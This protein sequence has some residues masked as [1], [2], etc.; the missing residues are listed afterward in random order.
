NKPSSDFTRKV[1]TVFKKTD[2]MGMFFDS[3]MDTHV[4]QNSQNAPIYT[5]TNHPIL[6]ELT[7]NVEKLVVTCPAPTSALMDVYKSN[8]PTKSITDSTN[9]VAVDEPIKSV[10]FVLYSR[11]DQRGKYAPS[12]PVHVHT[13]YP[14]S[15]PVS[16]TKVTIYKI[17][18]TTTTKCWDK[19]AHLLK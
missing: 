18:K 10:T 6:S 17:D 7:S 19:N 16:D 11:K 3:F 14:S 12:D 15:N 2:D 5:S 13:A 1:L 9:R 8:N 4:N